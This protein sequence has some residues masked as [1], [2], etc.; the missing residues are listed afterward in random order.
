MLARNTRIL[1]VDDMM[2][3]RKLIIRSCQEIGFLNF[4]EAAD[5]AIAWEK[6]SVA[7]PPIGLI[8]CDWNMPN[9]SGLEFLKRLRVDE[10]FKDLPFILLTAESE[11]AQVAEAINSGVTSYIVKPFNTE[12]LRVK[13]EKVNLSISDF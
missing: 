1:V 10:R 2:T 7:N 9:V 11:K 12:T 6:L 3:M 5:G 4:V 8:I 13:L